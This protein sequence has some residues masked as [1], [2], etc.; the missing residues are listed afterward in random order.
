MA[1][2]AFW[3]RCHGHGMHAHGDLGHAAHAAKAALARKAAWPRHHPRQHRHAL[4]LV[5]W[6]FVALA[7]YQGNP[8]C[9]RPRQRH[10][11]NAKAAPTGMLLR[12]ACGRGQVSPM[13]MR[14]RRRHA[15]AK[16][17]ARR[18]GHAAKVKACILLWPWQP[19]GT[20]LRPWHT[21]AKA[22]ARRQRHA[23]KT[24]SCLLPWPG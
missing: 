3:A 21:L 14:P 10:A 1:K 15:T 23:A 8:M 4:T 24:K 5:A 17:K 11:A 16:P 12:H 22:K 7:H 19:I 18:H 13:D 2:V 20:L 6:V 9:T